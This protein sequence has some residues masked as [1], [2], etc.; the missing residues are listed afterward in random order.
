M[1]SAIAYILRA[2]NSGSGRPIMPG[3]MKNSRNGPHCAELM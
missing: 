3:E 1:L 2:D